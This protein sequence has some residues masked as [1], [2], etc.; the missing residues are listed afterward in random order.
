ME[1]DEIIAHMR[2]NLEKANVEGV[3]EYI[4]RLRN[5]SPNDKIF[6]DLCFEGRAALMFS[7]AGCE[8]TIRESPDLVLK[9]NNAQFYSEVKHFRL[10]KQD[11]YTDAVPPA[12]KQVYDVSKNKIKQYKQHFPN[13]LIIGNNDDRKEELDIPTAIDT[14][15]KD[16]SSNKCPEFAKLNGI[17]WI[18]LDWFNISQGRSV[19]FYSTSKPAVLL[20][21]ELYFLLE[22]IRSG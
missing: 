5:N 9:Y 15:N 11:E 13:I 4:K 18:S 8:V 22:N 10:K 21:Q 20:S 14:I 16:I 19:F 12:W 17:I 2:I 6:Q 7:Q 1:I 3:P